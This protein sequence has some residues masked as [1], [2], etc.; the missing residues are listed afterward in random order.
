MP[1]PLGAKNKPKMVVAVDELTSVPKEELLRK[2]LG[3]IVF[4]AR[5]DRDKA[6]TIFRELT[7]KAED[8]DD[9]MAKQFATAYL[10]V[11]QS[12]NDQLI[13]IYTS[14]KDALTAAEESQDDIDFYEAI[15]A[16][17]KE[18]KN[19]WQRIRKAYGRIS[20]NNK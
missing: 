12:S 9:I 14:N 5:Q 6:L 1:R 13:K 4:N 20:T 3:E 19:G 7:Q 2:L 18:D 10:K 8:E 15:E 11:A 17:K 16:A